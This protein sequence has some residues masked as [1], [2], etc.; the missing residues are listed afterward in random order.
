MTKA[1]RHEKITAV[2]DGV[3]Y[4]GDRVVEGTRSFSQSVTYN[5]TTERDGTHYKLHEETMMDGIAQAILIQLV[6]QG[7]PG[8]TWP[9]PK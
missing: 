2:I 5:G 8:A 3:S 4:T 6:K 7:Q 1:I 9:T